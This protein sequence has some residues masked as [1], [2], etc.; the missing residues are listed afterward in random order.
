MKHR[1]AV[2]VVGA[3]VVGLLAGGHIVGPVYGQRL[4]PEKVVEK[5]C[6]PPAPDKIVNLVDQVTFTTFGE[7]V[8]VFTVPRD[9]HLV[10]ADVNSPK[11]TMADLVEMSGTLPAPKLPGSLVG[12]GEPTSPALPSRLAAPCVSSSTQGAPIG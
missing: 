9:F 5:N 10:L 11:S 7:V 1:A 6:W 12:F 3:L 8:S 2:C 4:P